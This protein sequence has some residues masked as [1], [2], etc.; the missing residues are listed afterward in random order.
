MTNRKVLTNLQ[1][2]ALVLLRIIIGWHLLYEGIA[3]LVIP[4]WSS[5]PYLENSRW[6]FAGLFNGIAANEG[7]LQVVDF[8]N[9][10]GLIFIG[11]GLMLGFMTR[12]AGIAGIALLSLYYL[13]NPP[14]IGTD[15]GIPQEGHYLVF[16]KTFVEIIAI[17]LLVVFPS[18]L[19]FGIDR[20][21]KAK[22]KAKKPKE[23]SKTPE[24]KS[25]EDWAVPDQ[26]HRREVLRLLSMV[27]VLGAFA[28]G[29]VRKY[30]WNQV[31][32]I[33]GATIKVSDSRLKDLKG[34]VPYG[35]IKDKKISRIF[36]GGNLIGGWSHSRDL[37]YVSSLFKAYNTEKKVFE[38]L[39]LAEQA[40]VNTINITHTQLGL[41]NK[42]KRIFG[43]KLQ[44]MSQ[45]HPTPDDIYSH[46]DKVID[47]GVDLVQI[48]GN[49]C[50]WMVRDGNI[51]VL[52]K[53]TDHIKRQGYTAGLG[54]HS[55]QALIA[56]DEAGIEPDFYMKTF[57]HDNY[58]S[59]HPME[60]RI[61]FS[62]DGDRSLN[63]DEFHDNM[64]CLFADETV[65]F[66]KKKKIPW[67]AFKVLAGGAIKPQDGF[68][69][70]FENGADFICVGMFDYQVI[71]DVNIAIET[72]DQLSGRQREWYG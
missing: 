72:L 51:D 69:Y 52:V 33:S 42:Y 30:R 29:A 64:F 58:W 66:M 65:E 1:S 34:E 62:V 38:T 55:V 10:W 61:P 40:G 68:N 25:L 44:T 57:H 15:F 8:L 50:D 53:C 19:Y 49:C 26:I 56:C 45:V 59:A 43:S 4:D 21:I 6:I 35:M 31:N 39:A 41:I 32:A 5:A 12:I 71:D 27:P 70:A 67:I 54:A 23:E 63:H 14:F 60:K 22:T 16:S 11:L 37:L 7:I 48:Q 36:A 24:K 47:M 18:G 2:T 13:A 3:K 9:I 20:F 46:V 17:G 28:W